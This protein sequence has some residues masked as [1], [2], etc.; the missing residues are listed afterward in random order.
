M[1]Q[2]LEQEIVAVRS[3][4]APNEKIWTAVF[5]SSVSADQL[6]ILSYH[7]HLTRSWP[8]DT[9]AGLILERRNDLKAQLS[10]PSWQL[11]LQSTRTEDLRRLVTRLKPVD[12]GRPLI[13]LGGCHDGGYLVPDD[14]VGMAHSF[15]P[16][17][18]DDIRFD[19]DV[20]ARGL[21]V[22][23]ADGSVPHLPTPHPNY[24]FQSKFIRSYSDEAARCLSMDD[25]YESTPASH[26]TGDMLLEMDVEGAEYE[27]VHS[28]SERLLRRFRI[29][30]IEFHSLTLLG[31]RQ[32]FPFMRSAF[33]KLLKYHRV[34]HI[35]PNNFGLGTFDFNGIE[36]PTVLEMTFYR[37]DRCLA[38]DRY[39]S[40]PH[41]LDQE[42]HP[43]LPPVPL[44]KSWW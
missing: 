27:I 25:W 38:H 15:S 34:V 10:T 33:H 5:Q 2:L 7:L 18:G 36:L 41:A 20:A 24:T 17:V 12:P 40:F 19:V 6:R 11:P 9:L 35:H 44:P 37:S 43:R 4:H 16:G 42:N 21:Q 31:A 14:F 26:H 22:H 13:R 8:L 1:R 29:V 30:V 39:P 3:G 32:T 23:F 28:M